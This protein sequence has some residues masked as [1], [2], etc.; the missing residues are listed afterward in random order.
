M[1]TSDDYSTAADGSRGDNEVAAAQKYRG[2]MSPATDPSAGRHSVS[3]R[4][5]GH[6]RRHP[7][8][9]VQR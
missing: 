9:R 2:A 8:L 1:F 6:C 4:V 5:A 7:G 3:R